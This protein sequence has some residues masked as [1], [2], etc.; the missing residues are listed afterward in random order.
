VKRLAAAFAVAA[1]VALGASPAQAA[2][3]ASTPAATPSA[4][5]SLLEQPA[6]VTL[7]G[8][9]PLRLALS[10]SLSGLE[11]RAIIHAS[12]TSRTGFERSL[13]GNRLGSTVATAGAPAATLPFAP[14][15]GR[16]LTLHLQDPN[17][18]RDPNRVRLPLPRSS[19]TGVFPVEVELRDPESGERVASF[20]THLVAVAPAVNG[21][22][23]GEPLNVA[24]MWQIAADPATESDGTLR[25][26]FVDAVGPEGR[27]TRL[28]DAAARATD[29]P[30]TL[31]P[32]P[33]TLESWAQHAKTDA[34][35]APGLTSMR[36]AART[37]QV[38]TGPY[39]PIDI[40]S[41]ERAGL[42]DDA[43]LELAQGS[44]A[45]GNVLDTRLN[46]RT[47]NATP[48][49][50]AALARLELSQVDR[51][52]VSP[53]S[54][55]APQQAPQ[56]TP[57]QPF[58][59]E[60]G[61]RP[62]STVQTDDGLEHLLEGDGTPAL[63]AADFLAGLAVVAIEQP[64]E[65]RGVVIQMP[66][67]WDPEPALLSA[68]LKG[69]ADNPLIAPVTLDQLF[70]HVPLEQTKNGPVVRELAPL[71]ASAPT[72]N[73]TRYRSTRHDLDA[74]ATTVGA[75]DPQVTVGHRGLL[76]SLTSVWPG[77]VGRRQSAAR[78]DAID[79]GIATFASLIQ[80]PP[81]GLTVTLTS[82]TANLP[83]SF[84]N[85]TGKPVRLLITFQSDK[86]VFPNGNVKELDLPPRNTT[87]TFLVQTR[88]SGT[89]PL[90]VSVTTRDGHLPLRAARYTVRSTVFSGVGVFLTIGAGL[91]LAIWWITHWRRSRRR[92]I[93][94]A[95]IAT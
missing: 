26:G 85:Q 31:A 84:N 49:D 10:G 11:A 68:V 46:G 37:K 35:A 19:N 23:M 43:A 2:P 18:P 57:A 91:F 51:V 79:H 75:G 58:R 48:L 94:P 90:N 3:S 92:P 71:P 74:F 88:A 82:R 65:T 8:D 93:R 50:S 80:T 25:S 67:R 41:L 54:L 63:R 4:R 20:V 29:V 5:V 73:P 38:L 62:F 83:L 1:L 13:D 66:P 76:I 36:A 61:G 87:K 55:V 14:N 69:L 17:Q 60:S 9:V 34:A 24:W 72:V 56:F 64:N 12:S 40:P 42:G 81:S 86:L 33:E 44:I 78:L 47:T 6:W 16:T 77:A 39:V 52:V 59:L 7:G 21:A 32:G 89:F 95:P 28:A 70:A 22:R 27:L 45:L 15:G 30:L 53:D